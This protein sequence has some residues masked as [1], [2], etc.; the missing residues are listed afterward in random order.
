MP[1][2]TAIQNGFGKSPQ[3]A[4]GEK[5]PQIGETNI[6]VISKINEMYEA[7]AV[8]FGRWLGVTDKT[9][10]RKLNLERSL[11]VEELGRLIRSER[12]FE[13]VAAVMGDAQPKWWRLMVPLMDA[14]EAREMQIVARRR[15]KQT[16]ES[17]LDAD[18]HLTEAIQLTEALSDQDHVSVHLDALRSQRRVPD[19]AVAPKLKR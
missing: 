17:A 16:I 10:K 5:F 4:A 7:A 14:A 12:G 9:A 19:R 18:R 15:L 3:K 8:I 2:T 1:A 11:S 6:R 13:V